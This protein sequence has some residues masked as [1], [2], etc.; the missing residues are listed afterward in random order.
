[1][2]AFARCIFTFVVASLPTPHRPPNPVRCCCLIPAWLVWVRWRGNGTVGVG[3][4]HHKQP[5]GVG[6]SS[7]L[8][9]FLEPTSQLRR[10]SY[11][12]KEPLKEIVRSGLEGCVCPHL[13][14]SSV[15]PKV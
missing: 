10:V 15:F 13:G 5:T 8:V 2:A 14:S 3:T 9:E 12:L 4:A 6:A 7:A 11:I 1:V